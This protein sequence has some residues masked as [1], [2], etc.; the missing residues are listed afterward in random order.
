MTSPMKHLFFDI[1]IIYGGVVSGST[2]SCFSGAG[3]PPNIDRATSNII[4]K[5]EPWE[6]FFSCDN[7]VSESIGQAN[8]SMAIDTVRVCVR[9]DHKLS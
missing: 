8:L 6:T 3:R 9:A 4:D 5:F 7:V 1:V 2:T